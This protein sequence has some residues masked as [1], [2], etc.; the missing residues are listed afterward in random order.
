MVSL[1]AVAP[2]RAPGEEDVLS[3]N[4]NQVDVC[5]DAGGALLRADTTICWWSASVV[6]SKPL[7][8]IV[9]TPETQ[10]PVNFLPG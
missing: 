4:L 6:F 2:P 1:R 3:R 10:R 7:R 9:T 8:G 5:G